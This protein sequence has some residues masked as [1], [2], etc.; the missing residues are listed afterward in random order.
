[1]CAVTGEW[2]GHVK[3]GALVL[4]SKANSSSIR[5]LTDN[6]FQPFVCVPCQLNWKAV[7]SVNIVIPFCNKC[8][9][10]GGK[11]AP[12]CRTEECA[13]NL[14]TDPEQLSKGSCQIH[15]SYTTRGS[16]LLHQDNGEHKQKHQ[17]CIFREAQSIYQW[18]VSH[19]IWACGYW[20][21]WIGLKIDVTTTQSLSTMATVVWQA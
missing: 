7:F 14:Y 12:L 20:C 5:L 8:S 19:I 1:M 3:E 17:S 4:T 16:D 15:I 13:F 11:E 10:H 18:N 2:V 9:T 6:I 21:Y